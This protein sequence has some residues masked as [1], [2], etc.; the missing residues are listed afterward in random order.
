MRNY[1]FRGKRLDNGK[2]THGDL[3]QL[4]GEQGQG[5]KFIVDNRFGACIDNEGNFVNTEAPFVNEIDPE[6]VGQ[7]TGLQ[8][9]N[10]NDIY[11][12]DIINITYDTNYSEKPYY[13]GTVKYG[14]N[15]DYPA[16]DL[17][18]WIDCEMNALSWLKSE[19]DE[20]V[21]SYEVIGNI[22]DNPNLLEGYKQ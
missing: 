16:F 1:K 21:K 10:G 11:E 12:G 19:S 5:R 8:D 13:I 17:C 7:Y 2:W 20:S 4:L 9:K 6:T 22:Y 3:I 18:P 14:A 15:E